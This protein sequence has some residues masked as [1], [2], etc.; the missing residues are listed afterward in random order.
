MFEEASRLKIR[1][2]T[3]RGV[4]VVEDL[5]DIPLVD[6]SHTGFFSLDDIAKHL[7][8][9]LKESA[10]E[11]FVVKNPKNDVLE[12]KFNIV[13]HVIDTKL[14]EN[15]ANEKFAENKKRKEKILS[16]IERKQDVELENQDVETLKSMMEET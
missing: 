16:I 11:S 1:F 12:L 4:I 7:N 8:R 9:E 10:K 15:A 2:A 6:S 3:S 13:K 14:A 5:W